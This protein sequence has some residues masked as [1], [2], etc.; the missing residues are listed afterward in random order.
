MDFKKKLANLTM[1]KRG[2]QM[3][4]IQLKKSM[5]EVQKIIGQ[6]RQKKKKK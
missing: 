1:D 4:S 2:L 5:D 3:R 6:G